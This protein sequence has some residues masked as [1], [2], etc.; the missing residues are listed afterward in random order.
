M[1]VRVV[2]RTLDVR[3]VVGVD[4]VDGE[5]VVVLE[6]SAAVLVAAASAAT[7]GWSGALVM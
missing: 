2:V 4:V 1:A 7:A 3:V 5:L 6:V